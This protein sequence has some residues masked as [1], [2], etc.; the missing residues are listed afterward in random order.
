MSEPCTLTDHGHLGM[1]CERH[2]RYHNGKQRQYALGDD[3][4]S[5]SMRAKWDNILDQEG[6]PVKHK[7]VS[8][9]GKTW[10]YLKALFFHTINGFGY[11]PWPVVWKRRRTCNACPKRDP[12]TDSCKSCGCSLHGTI[13]GDKLRWASSTCPEGKW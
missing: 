3:P 13:I 8:F 9:F 4:V 5:I 1:H 10:N 2:K 7:P 11:A 6:R 12:K